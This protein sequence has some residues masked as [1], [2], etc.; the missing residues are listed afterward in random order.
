MNS[1]PTP[2][3]LDD[4]TPVS[5]GLPEAGAMHIDDE[6]VDPGPVG[7][8]LDPAPDRPRVSVTDSPTGARVIRVGAT[9]DAAV[10]AELRRV[11]KGLLARSVDPLVV[12]LAAVRDA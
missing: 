5:I 11:A 4:G 9:L 8:G 12:D 3:V 7:D 10:A 6:R 2:T 1:D